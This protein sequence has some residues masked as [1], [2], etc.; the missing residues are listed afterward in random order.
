MRVTI[1]R[2][3]DLDEIPSQIDEDYLSALKKLKEIENHLQHTANIASEG[4][5]VDSSKF[6]EQVRLDLS[7]LDKAVEEIQSLSLSYEKIRIESRLEMPERS[8]DE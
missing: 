1:Q 8:E 6:L 5:Y 3:L 2:T 7:S 4:L